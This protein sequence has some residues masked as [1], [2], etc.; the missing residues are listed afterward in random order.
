M[1]SG[2][3]DMKPLCTSDADAPQPVDI[4]ESGL[5]GAIADIVDSYEKKIRLRRWSTYEFIQRL[6][7][8]T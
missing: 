1:D 8:G 4:P 2:D 7:K 5:M 3:I 6:R